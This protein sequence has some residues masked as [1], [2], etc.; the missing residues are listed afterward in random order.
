MIQNNFSIPLRDVPPSFPLHTHSQDDQVQIFHASSKTRAR[1][2][3]EIIEAV[4][5][6]SVSQ[7]LVARMNVL[8]LDDRQE[9][10]SDAQDRKDDVHDVKED[11][12]VMSLFEKI[13][14]KKWDKTAFL[15]PEER[16]FMEKYGKTV[17]AIRMRSPITARFVEVFS[18]YCKNVEFIDCLNM[19]NDAFRQLY[20]FK[21][22]KIL[23]ILNSKE[24]PLTMGQIHL[25]QPIPALTDLFIEHCKGFHF[26]KFPPVLNKFP[27]LKYATLGDP[28]IWGGNVFWDKQNTNFYVRDG[29]HDILVMNPS[30]MSKETREVGYNKKMLSKNSV[31]DEKT[32]LSG[33]F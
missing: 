17:V 33:G 27:Q 25:K 12:T 7:D 6:I 32:I 26:H 22:L 8:S 10:V 5:E 31:V 3:Q 23:K 14:D 29:V 18:L 21:K 16:T 30:T 11:A 4:P 2:V 15:S 9:Q 19:D 20:R 24:K 1:T 13:L 28:A